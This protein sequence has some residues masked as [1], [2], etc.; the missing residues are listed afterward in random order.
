MESRL[1]KVESI[2]QGD[3]LSQVVSNQFLIN[4]SDCMGLLLKQ[5]T[6]STL[7]WKMVYCHPENT[8]TSREGWIAEK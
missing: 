5:E 3:F 8:Q 4:C 6:V 1:S 2:L 7:F